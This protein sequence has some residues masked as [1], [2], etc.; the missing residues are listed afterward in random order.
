MSSCLQCHHLINVINVILP[1]YQKSS[2]LKHSQLI[3]CHLPQ[4]HLFYLRKIKKSILLLTFRIILSSRPSFQL[5][6]PNLVNAINVTLSSYQKS[7]FYPSIIFSIW[8]KLKSWSSSHLSHSQLRIIFSAWA[9]KPDN[10]LTPR[11]GKLEIC[12]HLTSHLINWHKP[13]N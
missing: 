12:I 4:C 7:R 1:S 9:S 10:P 6:L 5:E 11:L 3:T 2:I 13:H 8:G